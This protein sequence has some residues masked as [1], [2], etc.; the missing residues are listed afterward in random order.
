MS[1][2]AR[3]WWAL[4]GFLAASWTV[5]GIASW[6]TFP[7]VREWYPALAKPAWTPPSWVFGPVWTLLYILMAVAAWLVWRK[8]GFAGARLALVLYF[9]QLALNG[10]WSGF[11]FA[12]RNP[13]AGLAD[14]LLLW[15]AIG[16]AMFT[17]AKISVTAAWLLVPY[18]AWVSYAA[19][20][21]F[22]IW[23]LNR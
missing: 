23:Q 11:F 15:G 17:F 3:E 19:A 20:L 18:L 6:L 10:A 14:I 4:A 1:L 22:A 21:N 5:Q 12:I 13:A 8:A 16:A 7:A 2:T 9:V